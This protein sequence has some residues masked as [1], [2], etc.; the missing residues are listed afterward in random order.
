ME[1]DTGRDD[2]R[3]PIT[4]PVP[5]KDTRIPS[6][7]STERKRDQNARGTGVLRDELTCEATQLTQG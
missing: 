2:A 6:V 4:N 1:R 5:A 7:Y 3:T